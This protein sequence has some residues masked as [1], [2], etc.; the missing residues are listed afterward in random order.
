MNNISL[1][2]LK[3]SA[4]ASAFTQDQPN[5]WDLQSI[6][7]LL[8][9]RFTVLELIEE[10][11]DGAI[12]LAQDERARSA[13]LNPLVKLKVISEQAAL[14]RKKL[15][16]FYLEARAAAKLSHKNIIKTWEAEQI[17]NIHFCTIEHKP[18][19]ES[20]RGL[21][22]LRAWLDTQ[23]A[24]AITLQIADALDYAHGQGVLHLKL[25]P[26]NILLDPEGTALITDFGLEDK[27]DLRWAHQE[28]AKR[29]SAFYCSPEQA[30]GQNVGAHS[31][32]YS[33]GV[34]LYEMLTDRVPFDYQNPDVVRH[35]HRT[36]MPGPPDIFRSD[37]PA[38]VSAVV[39]SLL[40]KQPLK[41][42]QTP[43][44]LQAALNGF[45]QKQETAEIS[46]NEPILDIEIEDVM[47]DPV[48]DDLDTPALLSEESFYEGNAHQLDWDNFAHR[49]DAFIL[50]PVSDEK[51]EPI[52]SR[53][54]ERFE[55]P[56]ITVIE[57]PLC[58]TVEQV[59]VIDNPVKAIASQHESHAVIGQTAPAKLRVKLFFV[60]L[61][62]VVA[63]LA[64]ML[65][66]PDKSLLLF[67]SQAPKKSPS[68]AATVVTKESPTD[69]PQPEK[70]ALSSVEGPVLLD[71]SAQPVPAAK[72]VW[73]GPKKRRTL[74]RVKSFR[75]GAPARK[76]TSSRA[77]KRTR[78]R[79]NRY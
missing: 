31:D 56:T 47:P 43:T 18:D 78:W 55:P 4:T 53:K 65:Y 29:M 17:G 62:V 30:S 61:I 59:P 28:R 1:S 44:H 50:K 35:K 22:D 11:E 70:P 42:P 39:M 37:L 20:L 14:D 26:E 32:L 33:L 71:G 73:N 25:Q 54:R 60:L 58:E 49:E 48:V 67:R 21:L 52:V 36:Q 46:L 2:E 10:S 76:V 23:L 57:P 63:A 45:I 77:V 79:T 66:D 64:L 7:R 41:R 6:A 19:C 12:F 72:P 69:A 3:G 5:L 68:E 13:G 34:I 8:H 40:E 27:D 16:L 75:A 51:I 38:H 74:G 15:E 24:S 9:P